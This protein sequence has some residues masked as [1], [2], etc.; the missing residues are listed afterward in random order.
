MDWF[1]VTFLA[2]IQGLTE[3]LPISSSAHLI[4]PS[5]LF[6]WEDQGLAFDVGVH[7]GTL[8]A[9]MLYFRQDI[10]Q[11]IVAWLKSPDR[12]AESRRLAGLVC[13]AGDNPGGGLWSGNQRH[14]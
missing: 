5:Q 11:M 13:G 6:G 9:V 2:L 3:F 4:L 14:N 12:Q 1:Q 7:V 10:A 8:S